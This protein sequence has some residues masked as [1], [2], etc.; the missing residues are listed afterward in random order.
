MHI[1][2]STESNHTQIPI[3]ELVASISFDMV[4]TNSHSYSDIR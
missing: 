4:Q 1:D 3:I 2:A